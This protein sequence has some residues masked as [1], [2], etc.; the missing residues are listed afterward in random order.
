M[1]ARVIEPKKGRY[2]I[3]NDFGWI[4]GNQGPWGYWW[5]AYPKH[6]KVWWTKAKAQKQLDLL[7]AAGKMR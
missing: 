1:T 7:Q 5:M 2:S 3:V 6:G 4:W